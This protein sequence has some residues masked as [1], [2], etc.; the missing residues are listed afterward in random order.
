MCTK[1]ERR[2][3]TFEHAPTYTEKIEKG[4]RFTA[5]FFVGNTA[6][7][8]RKI[9]LPLSF[10]PPRTTATRTVDFAAYVPSRGTF[11]ELALEA[12]ELAEANVTPG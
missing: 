3:L 11:V 8:T 1:Q 5:R 10:T 4:G 2:E 7:C 6:A 12:S 9:N